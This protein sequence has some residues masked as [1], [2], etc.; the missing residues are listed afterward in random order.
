MAEFM[1]LA[2]MSIAQLIGRAFPESAM[3]RRHATPDE[4]KMGELE[5]AAQRL[6]SPSTST[7]PPLI[8]RLET[9]MCCY[10]ARSYCSR[11]RCAGCAGV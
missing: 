10:A 1:L 2:N 9:V 6:V 8:C 7:D 11:Q 4:R 3:L 5:V